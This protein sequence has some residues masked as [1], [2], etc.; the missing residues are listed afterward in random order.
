MYFIQKSWDAVFFSGIWFS[1]CYR[2]NSVHVH[3]N[4]LNRYKI[5]DRNWFKFNWSYY[6]EQEYNYYYF[7]ARIHFLFKKKTIS[8]FFAIKPI[9]INQFLIMKL[10]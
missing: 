7:I 6:N 1:P 9:K 10:S 5:I 3:S 4:T 2:L 8:L